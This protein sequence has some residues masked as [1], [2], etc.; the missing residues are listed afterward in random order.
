MSSSTLQL[1]A[2]YPNTKNVHIIKNQNVITGYIENGDD[3]KS[4]YNFFG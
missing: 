3:E 2:V 1:T 4:Q